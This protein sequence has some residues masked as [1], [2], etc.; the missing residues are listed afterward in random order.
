MA[1]C[2]TLQRGAAATGIADV[3]NIYIST[4]QHKEGTVVCPIA[5]GSLKLS[6]F[7]PLCLDEEQDL[8]LSA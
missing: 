4:M 8:V 5:A 3:S 7:N 1:K 2:P 6:Q